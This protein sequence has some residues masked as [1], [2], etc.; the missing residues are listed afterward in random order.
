MYVIAQLAGGM[1]ALLVA[2]RLVADLPTGGAVGSMTILVAEL[3]GMALFTFGIAA[4]VHGKVHE[5]M[6]GMMVGGSLLLGIIVAVQL[7]SGGILNP[8]VALALGAFN[9]H[10][11]LG[12]V[13]GAIVGMQCYKRCVA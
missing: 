5:S 10:Y 8:A 13:L 7:G 2:T 11:V 9:L 1:A 6:S 4:V 12:S 3:V